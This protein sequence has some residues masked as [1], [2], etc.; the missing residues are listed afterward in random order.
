MFNIGDIYYQQ[1]IVGKHL[2]HLTKSK[3][4]SYLWAMLHMFLSLS[5]LYFSGAIKLLNTDYEEEHEHNEHNELSNYQQLSSSITSP[6]KPSFHD[7][8]YLC[9][10]VTISLL[11]I[12]FLRLQHKG[13]KDE[14]KLRLRRLSYVFKA[15]M[16]LLCAVVPWIANSTTQ[17]IG[18][19][20]TITGIL[21]L[22]V[23]KRIICL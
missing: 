1:Q 5:I 17:C 22:Q 4:P 18:Y 8:K 7:E 23:I 13:L 21:I 20:F 2:F 6:H 12:Y 15:I 3:T 11:L 16:S 14:G 19:L 10:C 9:F